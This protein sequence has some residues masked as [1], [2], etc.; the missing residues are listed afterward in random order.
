MTYKLLHYF[1]LI[2]RIFYLEYLM[3]RNNTP[4]IDILD[5][6]DHVLTGRAYWND[7][8]KEQAAQLL[9]DFTNPAEGI[10]EKVIRKIMRQKRSKIELAEDMLQI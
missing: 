9:N 5:L 8:A 3:G 4:A 10:S 2:H 7:K 6:E 1:T